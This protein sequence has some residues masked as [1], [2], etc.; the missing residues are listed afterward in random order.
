MLEREILFVSDSRY[1]TQAREEIGDLARIEIVGRDVWDRVFELLGEHRGLESIG[2]ESHIV[3]DKTRRRIEQGLEATPE[4]VTDIVERLRAAKEP[5]EVEAIRQ[6]A[7][8]ACEALSAILP[9]IRVGQREID[10][11]A[12]LEHELRIRG[13]EW[14]PFPTI[15][16]SGPRTALPH[17]R[18]TDRQTAV[19][20][21]LLLDFGA[22]VDGYC[23]DVT[24]TLVVGAR[25][26]ERQRE[27]YEIVRRAQSAGRLEIRP[28]M[29]GKD[30]DALARSVI[31][32]EGFGEAFRHSL[33]HGLG[34]EVHEAPRVSETNEQP[35][36]A[37]AVFT[38]EPGIYLDGFG[39]VRIED[40]V[41][42]GP[43]GPE[44]LSDGETTL[45]ELT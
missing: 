36:P 34:L 39:G 35:L 8:L 40:D 33:G 24:R 5:G 41:Y 38:I 11:A 30:A 28:G 23:A 10:I 25:A 37:G 45:R 27:I 26:S 13:S 43:E 29:I 14:F 9:T 2:Y 15:V 20:D 16:A 17:A 12:R 4:P 7:Q 31:E 42:L 1:D 32:A 22:Q 6:A 18:T 44:L 19:G 21:L 3:T